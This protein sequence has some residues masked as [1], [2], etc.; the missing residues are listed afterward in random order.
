MEKGDGMSDTPRTDAEFEHV[1]NLHNE[2]VCSPQNAA[3]DFVEADFAR[4]LERE[5]QDAQARVRLLIA[6]RDSARAIADQNWKLRD[7]FTALLGTNDVREGVRAVRTL[8]NTLE[9][10]CDAGAWLR[11][12]TYDETSRAKDWDRLEEKARGLV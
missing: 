6:E 4:Q 7:E 2:W 10:L 9:M 12:F 11:R 3:I 1:N 5:L 8:K